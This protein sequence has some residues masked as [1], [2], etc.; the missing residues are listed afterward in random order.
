MLKSVSLTENVVERK[1]IVYKSRIDSKVVRATPEKMKTHL[2]R[3]LVF[4]KPKPEEVQVTSIV[5]Y[6]EPFVVVDGEYGIEYSKNW[7]HKIQVDA[8]MHDFSFLVR[9]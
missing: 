3:K 7:S 6:F 9:K 2:F 4:M 1:V 8:T 5:T